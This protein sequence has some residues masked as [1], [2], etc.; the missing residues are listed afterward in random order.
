MINRLKA[1]SLLMGLCLLPHVSLA[2]SCT[3]SPNLPLVQAVNSVGI[4]SAL[5]IGQTVPGT[6]KA[7]TFSG[8]CVASAGL[9]PGASIISCYYGSGTEVLPG[10]YSTGSPGI[11]IRLRNSAGVPMQNAVGALCDTR[12]AALGSLDANLRYT[13]AVT[14]EFVKT[15]VITPG[16]LDPEQTRFGFGVYQ[17]A[18]LGPRGS[19][20][21]G[22]SGNLNVRQLT[23]SVTSPP[24]VTLP[25]IDT[26]QFA[27]SASTAGSK[28]FTIDLLCDN[29]AVVGITFDAAPGVPIKSAASGVLGL[30][31]EGTA[32]MARGV[33]VQLVDSTSV[34]VPLRQRMP[35]GAI[36]ANVARHFAYSA[37]YYSLSGLP[38]GGGVD[39]A[40]VFT[41][42]YQ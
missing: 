4:T 17:G 8:Q 5:S 40:M 39:S 36:V 30:R 42:D 2:Q 13:V 29:A 7:Y 20:Y 32:G 27:K 11:G 15:G 33:G 31:N 26:R 38:S 24:V 35:L 22:L 21:I 14:I 37:R 25:A 16:P 18:A 12:R 1:L 34:A 41:F 3:A 19:N 10:V 23:C 6:V 28:G 9:R